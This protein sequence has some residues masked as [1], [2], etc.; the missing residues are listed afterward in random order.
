MASLCTGCL[1]SPNHATYNPKY[2][3]IPM[4]KPRAQVT[5]VHTDHHYTQSYFFILYE[6]I[7]NTHPPPA[8]FPLYR[9]YL[10]QVNQHIAVAKLMEPYQSLPDTDWI[11]NNLAVKSESRTMYNYNYFCQNV[12]QKSRKQLLPLTHSHSLTNPTLLSG[13]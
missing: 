11:P 1:Q 2:E 9:P 7:D 4:Q 10:P 5:N 8:E 13:G 6:N 12:L 3:K